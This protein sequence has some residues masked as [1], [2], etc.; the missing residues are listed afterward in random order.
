MSVRTPAPP[1]PS[2]VGSHRSRRGIYLIL[3]LLV[4]AAIGVVVALVVLLRSGDDDA[5][6]PVAPASPQPTA[7]TEDERV[8]SAYKSYIKVADEAAGVADADY[9]L[10]PVYAVNPHLDALRASLRNLQ[11]NGLAM[12]TPANSTREVRV[13][14]VSM[15]GDRAQVRVCSIDDGYLARATD[16]QAFGVAAGGELVPIDPAGRKITSLLSAE[17]IRNYGAWKVSSLRQEQ[18]WEGVAGCAVGQ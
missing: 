17:M 5:T 8:A 6:L 11:E 4:A 2:G 10:L 16:G 3:G 15:D 18:E 13:T 14:V 9:P 12:R 7:Q 1:T